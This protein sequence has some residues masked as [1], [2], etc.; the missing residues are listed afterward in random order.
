MSVSDAERVWSKERPSEPGWYWL[1]TREKRRNKP[2]RIT[3]EIVMLALWTRKKLWVNRF[4][5]IR[6]TLLSSEKR[7]EWSRITPPEV[8]P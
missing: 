8:K 4:R 3:D 5:Q 6:E 7:G 1:R 2:D